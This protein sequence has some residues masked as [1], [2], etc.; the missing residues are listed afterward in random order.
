MKFEIKQE[1]DTTNRIKMNIML[2]VR[3]LERVSN[4][5]EAAFSARR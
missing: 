4:H 1:Y 5:V 3:N 2:C